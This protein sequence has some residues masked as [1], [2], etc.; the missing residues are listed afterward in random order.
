MTKKQKIFFS[1]SI[2][3]LCAVI[4]MVV[5]FCLP[6]NKAVSW[7]S[8]SWADS[9]IV[10]VNTKGSTNFSE[11]INKELDDF[12]KRWTDPNLKTPHKAPDY[13][14]RPRVSFTVMSNTTNIC[15]VR[16]HAAIYETNNINLVN[17]IKSEKMIGEEIFDYYIYVDAK[18]KLIITKFETVKDTYLYNDDGQTANNM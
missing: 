3:E 1:V 17:D 18:S 7:R 13:V 14:Y 16:L 10:A 4:L 5:I 15:I 8:L 9:D 12:S 11:Q 6:C 2:A